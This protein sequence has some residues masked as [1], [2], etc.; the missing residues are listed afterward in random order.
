MDAWFPCTSPG[1][2]LLLKP[3]AGQIE[4]EHNA[5][6][7]ERLGLATRIESIFTVAVESFLATPKP[8]GIPYPDITP[9][10][11]SWLEIKPRELDERTHQAMWGN[12]SRETPSGPQ[13]R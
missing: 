4:Q 10:F 2:P 8:Y 6:E 11:V 3:F 13:T 7:A 5:L 9:L 12:V 1:K